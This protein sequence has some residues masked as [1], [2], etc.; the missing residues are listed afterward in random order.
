MKIE[1]T[2]LFEQQA[3][4]LTKLHIKQKVQNV[5]IFHNILFAF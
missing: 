4:R 5:A 2:K 3:K 1:R